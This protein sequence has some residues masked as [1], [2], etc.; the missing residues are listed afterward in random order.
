VAGSI[1]ASF[2]GS[3]API[4]S[5]VG[6]LAIAVKA[7][8]GSRIASA[9]SC[10][11]QKQAAGRKHEDETKRDHGLTLSDREPCYRPWA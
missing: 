4:G 10:T 6:P 2:C 5:A 11:S 8:E 9:L 1:G 3:P 7:P